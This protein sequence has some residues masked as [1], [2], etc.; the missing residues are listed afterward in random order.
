MRCL[1]CMELKPNVL[2][3]RCQ[4]CSDYVRGITRINGRPRQATLIAGLPKQVRTS[5]K[6]RYHLNSIDED[7][8]AYYFALREFPGL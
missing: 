4:D 2:Q 3:Y 5:R 1:I 6:S 8:D 7:P